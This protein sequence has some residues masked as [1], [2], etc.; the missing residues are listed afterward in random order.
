VSQVQTSARHKSATTN[1]GYHCE[2]H[3]AQALQHRAQQYNPAEYGDE[4]MEVNNEDKDG[5]LSPAGSSL[6][7]PIPSGSCLEKPIPS[8]S[9]LIKPI[10][11]KGHR[12]SHPGVKKARKKK[13]CRHSYPM[14]N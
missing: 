14:T 7:K 4:E 10:P 1:A 5:F 12:H 3:K 2:N 9:A 6:E 13:W 11:W 8:G